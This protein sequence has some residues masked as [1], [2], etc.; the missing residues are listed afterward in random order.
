[1]LKITQMS[2]ISRVDVLMFFHQS[3]NTLQDANSLF[4]LASVSEHTGLLLTWEP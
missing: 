2:M 4:A 1:M 3:K